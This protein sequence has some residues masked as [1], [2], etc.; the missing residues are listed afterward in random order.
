MEAK[1]DPL[2]GAVLSE[3]FRVV[4]R[5]GA[6]GFGTVY[7]AVHLV[8]GTEVA[9]K[10]ASRANDA[11]AMREAMSAAK[12]R[13]PYTVRVFDVGRL[14]SGAPYIVMEHLRGRSLR[15]YLQQE[16]PLPVPLATAWLNQIC[17]A[18]HE[19]H[20]LG[21]VHR[22]IKP[23]NLFVVEGPAVAVHLKLLDFG[24][25]KPASSPV[26]GEVTE[27]KLLIG[28]PAY[29]SP[30]QVRASDVTRRSDIWALGVVLFECLS[31]QRPFE[32]ETPSA[33]L[34]AIAA[35]PPSSLDAA[36]P[37]VPPALLEIV[38]KCLRKAPGERFGSAE[39]LRHALEG[40]PTG[41]ADI[42]RM[43]TD[44]TALAG[45]S[46]GTLS[47]LRSLTFAVPGVRFG[48]RK[49]APWAAIALAAAFGMLALSRRS[50]PLAV[51]APSVGSAAGPVT[52][53]SPEGG[54]ARSRVTVASDTLPTRLPAPL[55]EP[56][57]A[58]ASPRVSPSPPRLSRAPV[59]AP[60]TSARLGAG[61]PDQ[62]APAVTPYSRLVMD[63]DF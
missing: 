24:L 19:A 11:R 57:L 40:V 5:L 6:G 50:E 41:G 34:V 4:A 26:T 8:L 10:V 7:S 39:E 13:S 61:A 58:A 15:E 51:G 35:D 12:L 48:Y 21:L 1:Y 52:S 63:P 62:E 31:G 59:A 43:A 9:I 44:A 25:A 49:A 3:K 56:P 33:T 17:S 47:T 14:E 46:A 37:H 60:S 2:I 36:A 38:A 55:A 45:S 42:G 20:A 22:D 27:G 54:D 30:E 53:A 29:M 18:V 16:G 32:R 23:S 28:S